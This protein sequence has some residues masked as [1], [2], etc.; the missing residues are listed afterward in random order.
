MFVAIFS[1]LFSVTN[2]ESLYVGPFVGKTS[3]HFGFHILKML[4]NGLG[5]GLGV[6]G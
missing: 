4:L 3:F 1:V 2:R 6:R 5:L